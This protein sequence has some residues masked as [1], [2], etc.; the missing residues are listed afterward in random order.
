MQWF[1]QKEVVL[2]RWMAGAISGDMHIHVPSQHW[3]ATTRR[4]LSQGVAKCKIIEKQKV[5]NIVLIDF[6]KDLCEYIT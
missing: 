1:T 3:Q 6:F 5:N 4:R 2:D